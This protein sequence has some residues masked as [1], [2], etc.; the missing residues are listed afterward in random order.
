LSLHPHLTLQ[1]STD[2]GILHNYDIRTHSPTSQTPLWLL[3]AHDATLSTFDISPTH[4]GLIVTGSTDKLVKLWHVSALG[5]SMVLSRDLD[6]GKIFATQFGPDEDVAM[7]VAVAGSS[8]GVK[9][10]DLSTSSAARRAFGVVG[11]RRGEGG[12]EEGKVVGVT[13]VEDEEDEEEGGEEGEEGE[14]EGWENMDD[15]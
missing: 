10:W 12:E 3:Q 8:A 11:G 2:D 13:E 5:P 4:P 1:V 9:V 6:L 15:D 14:G 7:R